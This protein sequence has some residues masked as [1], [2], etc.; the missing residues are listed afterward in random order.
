M[1]TPS[2]YLQFIKENLSFLA[3]GFL[4][5]FISGLGQTYFISIFGAEIRDEFGLTNGD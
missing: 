4:L 2:G 3:A 5:S 1:S